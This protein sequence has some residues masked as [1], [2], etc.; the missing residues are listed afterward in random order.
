MLEAVGIASVEMLQGRLLTSIFEIGHGLYPA[1]YISAGANVR[2]AVD[3][4]AHVSSDH[5]LNLFGSPE[6]AHYAQRTF[7]F[8]LLTDR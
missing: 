3:L 2:A 1:A 4:G 5:T 8:I 6:R 7:T